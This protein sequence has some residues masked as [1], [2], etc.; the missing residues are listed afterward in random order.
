MI[1]IVLIALLVVIHLRASYLYR[2]S[3]KYLRAFQRDWR[4][5]QFVESA[6]EFYVPEK[7]FEKGVLLIHGFSASPDEFRELKKALKADGIPYLSPRLTGFGLKTPVKLKD[8]EPEDWLND[9]LNAYRQLDAVCNEVEVVAHSMGSMIA[10]L[11]TTAADI[12]KVVV[13]AP[14]LMP[15]KK[16]QKYVNILHRPVMY[17]IFRLFR[18]VVVKSLPEESGRRLVYHT[19]PVQAIAALWKLSAILSKSSLNIS[20]LNVFFGSMDNTIEEEEARKFLSSKS[21]SPRYHTYK[22]SGHNILEDRESEE[23]VKQIMGIIRG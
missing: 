14:Y 16:H 10:L 3:E 20:S 9:A 18:P 15:K 13:T 1:V 4:T 5:H 6:T 2:Q 23:V 21:L 11:L 22:E 12:K 7:K 8:V 17:H 19:V